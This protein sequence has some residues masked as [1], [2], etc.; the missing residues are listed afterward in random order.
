MNG[1]FLAPAKN[2]NKPLKNWNLTRN[3]R[4]KQ[5][6]E[7]DGVETMAQAK[8]YVLRDNDFQKWK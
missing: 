3:I 7:T 6:E 8:V 2:R 5:S 1:T 4:T